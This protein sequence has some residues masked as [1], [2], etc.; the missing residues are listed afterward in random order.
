MT[1]DE[2]AACGPVGVIVIDQIHDDADEP[3]EADESREAEGGA[4][5]S[6]EFVVKRESENAERT[7]CENGG[8]AVDPHQ[9]AIERSELGEIA[10]PIEAVRDLEAGDQKHEVADAREPES[11]IEKFGE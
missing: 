1:D 5:T 3:E 9:F 4:I 8:A 7:Y 2:P 6:K 11:Q 10:F